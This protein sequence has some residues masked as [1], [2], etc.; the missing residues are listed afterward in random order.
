MKHFVSIPVGQQKIGY[1]EYASFDLLI[2]YEKLL[3]WLQD[4]YIDTVEN[5]QYL[6]KDRIIKCVECRG[7]Q[8]DA[9][10]YSE[11][12]LWIYAEI[13]ECSGYT[14]VDCVGHPATIKQLHRQF[15]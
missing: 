1:I 6:S 3:L 15:D 2:T 11:P 4:R 12:M 8:Y 5:C 13:R 9:G 14:N 10:G 7:E